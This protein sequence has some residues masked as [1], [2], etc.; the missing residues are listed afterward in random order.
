[1]KLEELVAFVKKRI[2]LVEAVTGKSQEVYEPP[3]IQ[4]SDWVLLLSP[5]Y[6]DKG[7]R[8]SLIVSAGAINTWASDHVNRSWNSVLLKQQA[9]EHLVVWTKPENL[10]DGYVTL[11]DG[12]QRGVLQEYSGNL[13]KNQPYRVWCPDC[14]RLYEQLIDATEYLGKVG[15]E[16]RSTQIWQCPDGHILKLISKTYVYL[17]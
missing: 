15:N 5:A 8:G 13:I 1:M 17:S 2:F 3:D 11:L 7:M 12:V 4:C 16:S 10:S 14:K 9:L 6:G